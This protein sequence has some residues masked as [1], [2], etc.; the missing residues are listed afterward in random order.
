MPSGYL[1]FQF[2]HRTKENYDSWSI[3]M[4]AILGSQD[5]WDIVDNGYVEPN[6]EASFSIYQRDALRKVHKKD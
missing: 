5:V 4:K 3:H 1:P 2:P 6:E